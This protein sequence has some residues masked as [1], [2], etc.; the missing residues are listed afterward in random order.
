VSLERWIY[1]LPLRLR[2]LLRR[3]RVDRELDE[4]I[5]DHLARQTEMYIAQGMTPRE[6]RSAA[7]RRFGA[8]EQ[9]K[10][11]CRDARG[12]RLVHDLFQDLRY[13]ARLLRRGPAFTAVAMI[14]LALGIGA[15]TAIVQLID[16]VRFRV[17]PVDSPREL[18]IV[19]VTNQAYVLGNF[20]G[21]HAD[22]TYP[23]WE[24]LRA[25]QQAFSALVAWS[26]AVFDLASRGESRFAEN[27][28][29]VSGNFFDALGVRPAL[30]RLFSPADDVKGCGSPGV[31]LSHAFW[32]REFA[33]DPAVV[34]RAV[35]INGH[36][37]NVIGVTAPGFFGVEVGRSFDLAVPLCADA[38]ING[39]R[40]RLED[41]SAWWLAIMGRRKPGWSVAQA[42]AHVLALS[43]ALF[44]DTLPAG[45]SADA[46]AAYLG[47][48]LGVET[49]ASGYSRLR[50][51]Y[52]TPLVFLLGVAGIV[53]L[54]ACA[55]LANLL[56][57]RAGARER[58][59]AVRLAIGASRGRLMRQL[60][61]ES[62]LLAALGAVIG[63]VLA[64]VL[65]RTIVGTI[66]SPVNPLFVDL[67][68]DWRLVAVTAA[69]AA[70]TCVLFGLW[71]A[72]RGARI[73]PGESMKSGGRVT[74]GRAGLRRALVAAQ[75]ALALVLL[76]SGLLFVRS[77]VNLLTVDA[78]FRQEGLLE[79]DV[80]LTRIDLPPERRH[81]FRGDLLDRVRAIPEVDAAA[82]ASTVPL[83]GNWWRTIYADSAGRERKGNA[84]FNRVS[85]GYFATMRTTLVD[86][87]DFDERD[88]PGS[89][90]VA[91]VNESFSTRFVGRA[92][93]LGATFRLEG[94][95]GTPEVVVQIVG[96]VRDSKYGSL[97][98]EFGPIV[99]LAAGQV[100]RPGPFDQILIRSS[101]P[102]AGLM[103]SV[104]HAL[105]GAHARISFH[106]HDFQEQVRYSLLRD[107]LMATLCG[108]FAAL[109]GLLSTIGVYG[110]MS[111][112]VVQRTNEIGI[113]LALGA[114]RHAILLMV[115]REAGAVVSFGVCAGIILAWIATR[116][117]RDLLYGLE[118]SDPA[119]LAAGVLLLAAA[120]AAASYLPARRAANA[121]PT[122][123]LRCD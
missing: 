55:N 79:A 97:R 53:L 117:A 108:F 51:E 28:L 63:G 16:A 82:T 84:R 103:R 23:Q 99:Y 30:G 26:S 58:E 46:A 56:L 44:R 59:M 37:L 83:V 36:P 95:A 107:R 6:A 80:D 116:A 14:S 22:L 4:E 33:G 111:Y 1:I 12:V 85:S 5:Q 121:D 113:R 25:S 11:E 110:V 29:W 31:V 45:V 74:T 40:G 78:G 60:L 48:T 87:R 123:A 122:T 71:P 9:R 38:L 69:L 90:A 15:N 17:L 112:S 72:A 114:P 39:D 62:L 96:L 91:V 61:T 73:A 18:A 75:V 2:S 70:L 7:L 106:F 102:L 92:S 120:A 10:E 49:G 57:A 34:G 67:K 43:P 13:A 3:G 19:R 81:S 109:A 93:P 77:L 88:T 54:I 118:P 52:D 8:V 21:R 65:S 47:F 119:T 68:V 94:P 64:Q 105:D 20:G 32:R 89:P 42:N 76:V 100:E 66:S 35:L 115:L 27:A 104:S 50:Q 24:Q 41:R 86:G 101:A 98:E